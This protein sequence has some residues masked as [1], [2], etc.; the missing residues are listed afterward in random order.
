MTEGVIVVGLG[1]IGISVARALGPRL[2]GAVEVRSDA[3]DLGVPVWHRIGEARGL[4]GI[5]VV[6][7]GSSLS[8]VAPTIRESLAANMHVVSTCEQLAYPWLR[9]T[10]LAD[11]LDREARAAGR[12]I[13]GA[14]VNPGFVMDR[15]VVTLARACVRVDG[16]RVFRAVDATKRRQPLQRKIGAGLQEAQWRADAEAGK[17]GHV[18]LAESAALIAR[19]L[20]W[21]LGDVIE[22]LNPIVVGGVAQGLRQTANAAMGRV[23]LTL[24][25]ALSHVDARD[26]VCIAGDPPVDMVVRG[27]IHGDRG[28]VGTVMDAVERV[29]A[30]SPGLRTVLDLSLC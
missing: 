12:V 15:L 26:T 2:V 1:P 14:G 25:M 16:I 3:E 9:Q 8:Q 7:T 18:G 29:V 6:T 11:E 13:L 30:L 20:N 21:D 4:G 28:T 5:A 24:E 17:I 19:G 23:E 27:G 22:T 10:A